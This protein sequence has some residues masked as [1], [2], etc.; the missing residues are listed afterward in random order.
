MASS[1]QVDADLANRCQCYDLFIQERSSPTSLNIIVYNTLMKALFGMDL[2]EYIRYFLFVTNAFNIYC[3][4][5]CHHAECHHAECHHAECGISFIVMLCVIM[6]R[7]AVML[8]GVMLTVK[9]LSVVA[10]ISDVSHMLN[11]KMF[12]FPNLKDVS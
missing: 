11:L 2:T 8:N 9:M 3:Y 7:S 1:T 4:A 10:P 12:F 6:L 5:E